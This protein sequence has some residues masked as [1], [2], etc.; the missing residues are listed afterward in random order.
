MCFAALGIGPTQETAEKLCVMHAIELLTRHNLKLFPLDAGR[1]EAFVAERRQLQLYVPTAY[2][3]SPPPQ[4]LLHRRRKIDADPLQVRLALSG[5]SFSHSYRRNSAPPPYGEEAQIRRLS[6]LHDFSPVTEAVITEFVQLYTN[7]IQEFLLKT[8]QRTPDKLVKPRLSRFVPHVLVQEQGSSWRHRSTAWFHV[9]V[10][11]GTGKGHTTIT[12]IGQ[13]V[14]PREAERACFVHLVFL[15]RHHCIEIFTRAEKIQREE[16]LFA[17][18]QRPLL[19]VTSRSAGK[20]WLPDSLPEGYSDTTVRIVVDPL[21]PPV[22][23]TEQLETIQRHRKVFEQ[24]FEQLQAQ[25]AAVEV[26]LNHDEEDD[27]DENDK[28]DAGSSLA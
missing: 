6:P 19:P 4:P 20:M 12:A 16:E 14:R 25:G 9:R 23:V 28:G 1:Q 17:S 3:L 24:L 27:S 8:G 26:E 10:P 11:R 13:G 7:R 21:C 22:I 18:L 5:P 2:G 15:L